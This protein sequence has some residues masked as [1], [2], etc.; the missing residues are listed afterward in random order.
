MARV[1]LPGS[2]QGSL[3]QQTG[4]MKYLPFGKTLLPSSTG[5]WA[6]RAA[7]PLSWSPDALTPCQTHFSHLP[8]ASWKEA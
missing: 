2:W 8:P 4:G 5:C 3:G 1:M 7:L 6:L